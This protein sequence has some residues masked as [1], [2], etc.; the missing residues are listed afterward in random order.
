MKKKLFEKLKGY[1]EE[2][3]LGEEHDLAQRVNEVGGKLGFFMDIYV[4][5]SVRRLK[6]EGL[7]RQTFK[8]LYSEF[9][10]AFVGKVKK[11]IIKYEFGKY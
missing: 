7:L 2:L 4:M 3:L 11:K 1:D 8:T 9:Y 5:N 10:R 6:K